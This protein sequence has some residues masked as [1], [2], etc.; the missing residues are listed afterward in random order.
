MRS[1]LAALLLCAALPAAAQEIQRTAT[2]K[3][4]AEAVAAL[5]AAVEGAGAKVFAQVDHGAGARS[6]DA[7]VGDSVLVVFGNP[8]VGTPVI[9]MDRAAALFLPLKVLVYEDAEGQ[10]WLAYEDPAAMLEGTEVDTGSEAVGR[11]RQALTGLTGR[12]AG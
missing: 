3:S 11:L 4:V 5:V 8:R 6:V 9:A 12:A 2:D 10:V 7:E 1:V